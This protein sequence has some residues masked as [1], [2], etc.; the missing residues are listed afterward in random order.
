MRSDTFMTFS[1]GKPSPVR[2]ID[3]P[4][5]PRWDDPLTPPRQ[6]D[7]QDRAPQSATPKKQDRQKAKSTS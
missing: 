7:E 5:K 4:S 3:D 1:A 6:R 2:V